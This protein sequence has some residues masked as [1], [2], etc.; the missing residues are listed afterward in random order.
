MAV[1]DIARIVQAVDFIEAHLREPVSVADM[2]AAVS[3]SLYHFCR[4]FKAFTHF[5][6][7]DYLM[8]RRVA[9]S[10]QDLLNGEQ[11]VIDVALDYQFN[12]PE[13]FSRAFKR[14][15]GMPPNQWRQQGQSNRRQMMPRL[16]AAHL[17]HLHRGAPWRPAIVERPALTLVGVMTL[18]QAAS[19]AWDWLRRELAHCGIT[20]KDFYEL[21][22]YATDGTPG[23]AT[24]AALAVDE[25]TVDTVEASALVF[26]TLP[27]HTCLSITHRGLARDLALTLDYAYHAWLPQSG[28]RPA[29]TWYLEHYGVTHD[30]PASGAWEVSIPVSRIE[31]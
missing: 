15:M 23:T 28:Y 8:R 25:P 5:T 16:T 29:Q 30:H 27:A 11:K 6:P 4:T 14:V 1:N 9:E 3:Y 12:N 31:F 13:T 17:E 26:K 20:G 2:A 22:S 7:Y 24:L 10:A 21:T 19:S 18:E